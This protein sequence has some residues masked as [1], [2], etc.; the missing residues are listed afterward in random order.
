MR[1]SLISAFAVMVSMAV[2]PSQAAAVS[3]VTCPEIPGTTDRVFA[4]DEDSLSFGSVTCFAYGP[5]NDLTGSPGNDS[6]IDDEG[7]TFFDYDNNPTQIDNLYF[8]TVG[9]APDL[10]GW[11]DGTFNFGAAYTADNGTLYLGFKVGTNLSPAWAVFALTGWVG[12]PGALS[13]NFYIKPPAGS[14]ISHSSIYGSSIP[15]DVVPDPA[16][17]PEPTSMLLLGTGLAG[18]A[19]AARRRRRG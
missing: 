10:A 17:V 6:M 12:E 4:I 13:G 16:A 9:D 1:R 5:G 11:V 8:Y 18:V 2:L 7:L 3:L 14:G 19:A 15:P